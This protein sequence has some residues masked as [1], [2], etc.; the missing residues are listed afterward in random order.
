MFP[1]LLQ[2]LLLASSGLF[3]V[4]SI[5]IV[6]FFLISDVK[7]ERALVYALG[8]FLSYNLIGLLMLVI[9]SRF[10]LEGSDRF[11][12]VRSILLILLGIFLIIISRR[13]SRSR[14]SGFIERFR[15]FSTVKVL[16][17]GMFIP[18]I[19]MKNFALYISSIS[20]VTTS[21][22]FFTEKILI[23]IV[24]TLLFCASLSV[25]IVVVLIFPSKSEQILQRLNNFIEH[26]QNSMR[27]YIPLIF[28][29]ILIIRG[30][31]ELI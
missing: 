30:G 31:V 3:S 16:F 4:G 26:H 21:L 24:A 8:Y 18:I 17:L 20:V 29:V 5:S 6:L 27:V 2:T 7:V 11:Y 13:K 12:M 22:L 28:G 19:N 9:N 10:T 14:D 23:T 25:P 1:V 15:E